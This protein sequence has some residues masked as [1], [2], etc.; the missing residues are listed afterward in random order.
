MFEQLLTGRI[1]TVEPREAAVAFVSIMFHAAGIALL[2]AASYL[3][4][5]P[6]PLPRLRPV[7]VTTAMF[8]GG[9]APAP[10]LG[11]SVTAAAAKKSEPEPSRSKEDL[12]QPTPPIDSLEDKSID[13]DT[14]SREVSDA[15]A[16]TPGSPEGDPLGSA[17]GVPGGKCVGENCNPEGPVGNGPGSKDGIADSQGP[18]HPG[19][20]AVTDPVIIDSSKTLPRYP[21]FARRAGV[22]GQAILRAVIGIDGS[23]GSIVVLREN[24]MHVGFGEA[25]IEAVSRWSYHPGTLRGAPVP[26]EITITVTFALSR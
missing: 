19:I 24:P 5:T 11:A 8:P 10:K 9:G 4:L 3:Y 12:T 6:L 23:V 13:N 21:D 16:S 22:E 26:V 14:A 17:V 2:L 20:D 15:T 1:R 18:F 25:A 7:L